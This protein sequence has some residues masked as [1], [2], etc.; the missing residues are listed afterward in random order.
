MRLFVLVGLLLFGVFYTTSSDKYLVGAV[1]DYTV[2]TQ[3]P[4]E[5]V[6]HPWVA[7]FVLNTR[8]VTRS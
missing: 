4:H 7:V 6:I 8:G 2:S 3:Y 5:V 1:G